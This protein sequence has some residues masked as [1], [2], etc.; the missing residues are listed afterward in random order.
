[1]VVEETFIDVLALPVNLLEPLLTARLT[2]EGADSVV[3]KCVVGAFG[4]LGSAFV[5]IL[6][7]DS[8]SGESTIAGAHESTNGVGALGIR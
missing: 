6:A 3:A 5:Y 8:V 2:L 1:M 4:W 7:S